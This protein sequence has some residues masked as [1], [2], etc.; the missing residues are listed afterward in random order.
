MAA[1]ER[2]RY[3]IR[4]A[5]TSLVFYFIMLLVNLFSR[6]IFLEFLGDTLNGLTTTMQFTIGLLNMADIGI[7]TAISCALFQPVFNN[8]KEEINRIISLFCFLF[9]IVGFVIIGIGMIILFFLPMWVKEE[10]PTPIL[11]VSFL[12]F[13]FTTSLSY[14]VN[15]KQQLLL[16]S[17]KT[18]I[19]TRIQNSVIILK[20]LAQVIALKY[21]GQGY[22]TWL[23]IEAVFAVLY[24]VVLEWKVRKEYPWLHPSYALG[25]KIRREYKYIFRNLKQIVSHKFANVILTQTD[26]II[27]AHVISLVTVTFYY[28]YAIIITKLTS[29][30]G[31]LFSGSWAG[32]GNLISENNRQKTIL[33]F[34]QYNAIT[35][36]L[37]GVICFC[38]WLLADPFI[39]VWI[40]DKYILDNRIFIV[41]VISL[42]I[43]IIRQPLTVF[44][45]GYS[46]Y[47]DTWSAWC[48][49]GMNLL[50]SIIGGIHFGLFG[51]VLGTAISTG[52]NT[53][54]WK[55]Y[56]LYREG[57]KESCKEFYFTFAKYLGI[58]IVLIT[59]FKILLSE[60]IVIEC[61][62]LFDFCI[63]GIIIF[64]G[65]S[66]IYGSIL[67]LSSSSM[68]SAASLIKVIRTRKKI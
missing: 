30:I 39:S 28:N 66:L 64:T 11:V 19:V 56:F 54:L 41:M 20:I 60:I 32:V 21:L 37:A 15:Y 1:T 46:L 31:A 59:G 42:Y 40:G 33:V 18:Y 43:A 63:Y 16:A 9:R 26:S 47:K 67:Y 34:K 23:G 5:K 6:K 7:V 2:L 45:N 36:F 27:I 50:I 17:Q 4:N 35:F 68:R 13:L 12:T 55:P 61:K 22:L 62:N 10:V 25:K 8:D 65:F 52:A 38:V 49:A 3:S 14:F 44:L 29:L 58:L 53:V 51:V 57:F 24:S 48:E